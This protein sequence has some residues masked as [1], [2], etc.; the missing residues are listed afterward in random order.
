[1]KVIFNADDMGF[2]PAVNAGIYKAF[3]SGIVTSTS[4]MANGKAFDKAVDQIQSAHIPT[5]IHFNLTTGYPVSPPEQIPSLLQNNG[6]FW[7]KWDFA[8][9]LLYSQID[10]Y[11]VRIELYNQIQKCINAGIFPDHFDGH[12]HVHLLPP[13]ERIITEL[14]QNSIKKYRSL[15]P[16]AGVSWQLS[17]L[18]AFQQFVFNRSSHHRYPGLAS[19]DYFMGMELLTQSD[20]AN[21]LFTLLQHIKPGITEIMCHPG[22][23][24]KQPSS[25]Y[26]RGREQELKVLTGSRIKELIRKSD[27]RL[28]SFQELG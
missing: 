26:N 12:H 3:V 15:S 10:F 21:V 27:I 2:D 13:I 22:Y 19:P 11:H 5:G 9:R 28:V 14:V 6:Q 17:P 20:K 1:M 4:L 23:L 16:P 24:L 18:A 25:I 8:R 7:T